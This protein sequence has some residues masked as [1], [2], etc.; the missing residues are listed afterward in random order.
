MA[1]VLPSRQA[2]RWPPVGTAVSLRPKAAWDT[3]RQRSLRA[4]LAVAALSSR[5]RSLAHA[6]AR[7][8]AAILS[9]SCPCCDLACYCQTYPFHWPHPQ[10]RAAGGGVAGR[11]RGA[12]PLLHPGGLACLHAAPLAP[13]ARRAGGPQDAAP[14]PGNAQGAAVPAPGA[15]G[16]GA[17]AAADPASLQLQVRAT[18]G[19]AEGGGGLSY[20]A[21]C[22]SIG[23]PLGGCT[24]SADRRGLCL[25]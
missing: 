7:W 18:R 17:A 12:P 6:L 14:G 13:A 11:R 8:A 22:S 3:A 23:V 5:L 4:A 19:G 1:G 24:S 16:A 21:A 2:T 9:S 25:Q 10:A 15:A 20:A